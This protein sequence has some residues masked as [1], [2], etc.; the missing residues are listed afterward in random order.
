VR[1]VL[2]FMVELGRALG[3]PTVAVTPKRFRE[4]LE[5]SLELPTE[6]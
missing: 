5:E 6:V 2:E 1:D 4:L 3:L